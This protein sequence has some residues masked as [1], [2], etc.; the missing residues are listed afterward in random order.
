MGREIRR[1]PPNW[2]HPTRMLFCWEPRKGWTKKLAYKSMLPTPHAEALAEWEAEKASWDAGERPKYVRADTTFVE[3]YGERPEPE[4]Y[5]PFSADEATWFQLWETVSEGSPTS[6]PFATL[7]ELAAYLAEW[8]DF[9]DQSRAVEDMPAREV[10]RLLLETDHQHE[11]KAGWG[12]ERAEAF[13]RSGWAPSMIVRNG[14]VLTNPGDMV[15]A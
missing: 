6:P 11:F 7:D 15:S 9:W 12:K 14:Q 8:G 1:V 2:S 4:Y 5:V 13:C 10:E 3:Y